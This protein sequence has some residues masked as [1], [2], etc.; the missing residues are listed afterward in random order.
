MEVE[1]KNDDVTHSV[2]GELGAHGVPQLLSLDGSQMQ[3]AVT[4]KG[5]LLVV[6][7]GQIN[8]KLL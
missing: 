1:M 4:L 5:T 6:K 8:G 7:T 2:S 3:G